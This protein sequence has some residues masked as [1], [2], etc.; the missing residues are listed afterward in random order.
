MARF[1]EQRSEDWKTQLDKS[2]NQLRTV[3]QNNPSGSNQRALQKLEGLQDTCDGILHP[4]SPSP[5]AI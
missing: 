5:N 3:Y 2:V 4:E 1:F